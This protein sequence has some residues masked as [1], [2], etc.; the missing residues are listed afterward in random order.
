MKRAASDCTPGDAYRGS[1]LG[2]VRENALKLSAEK[3]K[4]TGKRNQR[5]KEKRKHQFYVLH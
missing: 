2:I 1:G 5:L 4:S 3:K